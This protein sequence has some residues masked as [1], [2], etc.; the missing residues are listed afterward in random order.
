MT[1]VPTTP[2]EFHHGDH[3]ALIY[4]HCV[5]SM[6]NR[7]Q[8]LKESLDLATVICQSIAKHTVIHHDQSIPITM[9][10]LVSFFRSHFVFFFIYQNE[11]TQFHIKRFSKKIRII[12]QKSSN[13]MHQF[14]AVCMCC[15]NILKSFLLISESIN[16][17]S[18]YFIIEN[19]I[20]LFWF[21]FILRLS[22]CDLHNCNGI[23]A[24]F[25]FFFILFSFHSICLIHLVKG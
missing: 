24:H 20:F 17:S 3:W 16:Q 25:F 4:H 1:F 23:H 6:M 10:D 19:I 5:A 13:W 9:A 8:L 15:F 14:I 18:H 11:A 12:W 7:A 21:N 22:I 2:Q